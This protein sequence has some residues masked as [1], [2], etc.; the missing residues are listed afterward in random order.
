MFALRDRVVV[1]TGAASGI[2]A[3]LAG[4]LAKQGAALALI[5]RDADGLAATAEKAR[6]SGAKVT[7]YTVDLTDRAAIAGLP[8]KV[9]DDLGPACV[10]INNAGIALGGGFE[11]VSDGQF[12]R[13]IAINFRAPVAMVRAFL[14]QLRASKPAQIVNISSIFG[15]IGV[16]G[17]V[18]YCSAKFGL[19]GFSEALRG[20]LASGDVG[21]SVVHPGGVKTKIATSSDRGV[22]L[23]PAMHAAGLKRS[24]KLLTLDPEDAA[25][26]ILKGLLRREKRIVVGKDAVFLAL[27]ARVFPVAYGRFLPGR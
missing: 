4:Q 7:A 10:L 22:W 16:P 18:A 25:A 23:D 14:P 15:I 17:N 20:E 9:L 12:D 11:H 24:E 3:A 2:G 5:D 19:R 6:V 8:A 21:V 1:L 27:L 26:R 13:V